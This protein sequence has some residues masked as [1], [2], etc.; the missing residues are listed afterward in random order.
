M[1]RGSTGRRLSTH[2]R[3]TSGE[4][5]WT[6]DYL[7]PVRARA[8]LALI[9][10]SS[11]M[12]GQMRARALS[13]YQII[14]L[15]LKPWHVNNSGLVA[16]KTA[17]NQAAVW[18]RHRGLQLLLPKLKRFSESEARASNAAGYVVG[19]ATGGDGVAAFAYKNGTDV[20]LPG[21]NSK[22]LSVNDSDQ[23]VGESE[24]D[25]KPPVAAVLWKDGKPDSLGGCCGGVANG[26]NHRGQIIGNL[27]DEAGHYHAFLWDSAHGVQYLDP[28]SGYSSAIAINN[29][30]HVLLQEPER[31]VFVYRSPDMIVRLTIPDQQPAEGRAIN[32][33]DE[34]VGAY[35]PYFDAERAFLWS[36]KEGF[37][38]LNDLIPAK[39]GWKLQAA[40]GINDGGEIVGFGDHHGKGDAGFLLVPLSP[41][42]KSSPV[43][44][45]QK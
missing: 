7:R 4:L 31:G 40:T 2:T 39:S 6:K 34:V 32:D 27:Y 38:D 28:S 23:V 1:S 19:F 25:G 22:A 43:K 12:V 33:A 3:R 26:I 18:S 5:C 8:L 10:V 9:L 37:R 17:G 20:W 11:A 44:I 14:E 42:K 30:G 35:G 13:S 24:I 29:T 15:P 21:R 45:R 16:G 41:A 36:E